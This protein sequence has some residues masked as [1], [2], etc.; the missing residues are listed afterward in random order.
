[1]AKSIKSNA[2]KKI[3]CSI[4]NDF[5]IHKAYIINVRSVI[6]TK[7]SVTVKVPDAPKNGNLIICPGIIETRTEIK[8]REIPCISESAPI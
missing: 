4:F 7:I 2:G 8:R 3:L 5:L 6:I 1:M